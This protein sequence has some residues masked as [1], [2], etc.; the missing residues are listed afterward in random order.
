MPLI[1]EVIKV[2]IGEKENKK[3]N[4]VSFSNSQVK[5]RL[6]DMPDDVLVQIL[7]PFYSIQLNECTDITGLPQFSVF[8][9][10]INNAAVSE[11][12]LFC[13]ALKLDTKGKNIF[14][15]LND[16]FTEYSIPWRNVLK[17]ALMV[18]CMYWL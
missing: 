16:F 13:E 2:M 10:Y 6:V 14:Q 12:L 3:L 5:R 9:R 7:T 15:C 8:I 17:F 1:K 4:K 18:H 11:D